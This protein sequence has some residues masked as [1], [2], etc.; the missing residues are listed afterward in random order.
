MAM[1]C[2]RWKTLPEA[3]GLLDQPAGMME[4]MTAALNVHSAFA[5]MYSSTDWAKWKAENPDA[6]D[7]IDRVNELRKNAKDI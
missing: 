3:G 7:L 2:D 4:R 5:H 1:M 6:S